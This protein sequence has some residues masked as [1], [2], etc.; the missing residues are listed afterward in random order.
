M[1]NPNNVLLK[2]GATATSAPTPT[3]AGGVN[4][5]ALDPIVS[6]AYSDFLKSTS[7]VKGKVLPSQ[8]NILRQINYLSDFSKPVKK[9]P[10][11]IMK[12]L[13][14]RVTRTVLE[15]LQVLDV[16]RRAVISAGKEIYDLGAGQGASFQDFVSQVK[17]PTFGV[18]RFVNTGNKN[19]DRLLGFAGDVAADPMTYITLGAGKF[20][21]ASGRLALAEEL[22]LKG[23]SEE[24][25]QKAGVRGLTGLTSAERAAYD[26][27]KAGLYFGGHSGVRIPGTEMIGEG[28]GRTLSKTRAGLGSTAV[29]G[30]VRRARSD[31]RFL[32]LTE[33]LLA[34]KGSVS[35]VDA[36]KTYGARVLKDGV[37]GRTLAELAQDYGA[38]QDLISKAP[39]PA[40]VTA[41]LERGVDS[42][43]TNAVRNLFNKWHKKMS[44]AG[45]KVGFLPDY[46]PRVW[47]NEGR[48][49]FAG[50]DKFAQDARKIFGVQVNDVRAPSAVRERVFKITPG[51]VYDIGGKKLTFAEDSIDEINRVFQ[52]EFGVKVLEDDINNLVKGYANNVA[53]AIGNQTFAERLKSVGVAAAESDV[54]GEVV[55]VAATKSRDK[56][57]QKANKKFIADTAKARDAARTAAE[58]MRK[59]YTDAVVAVR[60]NVA[61]VLK[62]RKVKLQGDLKGIVDEISKFVSANAAQQVDLGTQG[63]VLDELIARTERSIEVA[64]AAEREAANRASMQVAG[65]AAAKKFDPIT[66][67]AVR[68]REVAF[69]VLADL[70]EA[71]SRL[72]DVTRKIDE[73]TVKLPTKSQ[74]PEE[75]R[76]ALEV[77]NTIVE[78]D[79]KGNVKVFKAPEAVV[80]D[81]NVE[82][83][84]MVDG[85]HEEYRNRNAFEQFRVSYHDGN[86]VAA[87]YTPEAGGL[88]SEAR[89][90]YDQATHLRRQRD[91]FVAQVDNIPNITRAYNVAKKGYDFMYNKIAGTLDTKINSAVEGAVGRM[92]AIRF[93]TA[94]SVQERLASALKGVEPAVAEF[95]YFGVSAKSLSPSITETFASLIDDLS[96]GDITRISTAFGS[97][98]NAMKT[99]VFGER[100]AAEFEKL[101]ASRNALQYESLLSLGAAELK[102]HVSN[103]GIELIRRFESE[104]IPNYN[105]IDSVRNRLLSVPGENEINAMTQKADGLMRQA[106]ARAISEFNMIV[107]SPHIGETMRNAMIAEYQDFFDKYMNSV[108]MMNKINTKIT[109]TD[110]VARNWAKESV[111][112]KEA[113]DDAMTRV[114]MHVDFV[115]RYKNVAT[116]LDSKG[117]SYSSDGLGAL[118]AKEVFDT[119]IGNLRS[120]VSNLVV[121]QQNAIRDGVDALRRE[122]R[123]GA[124]STLDNIAE[125]VATD[126]SNKTTIVQS[127][128]Q[129]WLKVKNELN[130]AMRT[131]TLSLTKSQKVEQDALKAAIDAAKTPAEQAKASKALYDFNQKL[132][133]SINVAGVS[134]AEATAMGLDYAN[135]QALGLNVASPDNARALQRDLK[136]LEDTITLAIFGEQSVRPEGYSFKNFIDSATT[137][138]GNERVLEP[139]KLDE[140]IKT[141]GLPEISKGELNT[142]T[143]FFDKDPKTGEYLIRRSGVKERRTATVANAIAD[144]IDVLNSKING[145]SS[146]AE[147]LGREPR[148]P[149]ITEE[150]L[151]KYPD[152][153]EFTRIGNDP[154]AISEKISELNTRRSQLNPGPR[155]KAVGEIESVDNQINSLQ[156]RLNTLSGRARWKPTLADRR[157]MFE[158]NKTIEFIENGLASGKIK[159]NA[160]T[161]FLGGDRISKLRD[162][163]ASAKEELT[164]IEQRSWHFTGGTEARNVFEE[165]KNLR[166]YREGLVAESR[167]IDGELAYYNAKMGAAGTEIAK[168]PGYAVGNWR[169]VLFD[170]RLGRGAPSAQ[171]RFIRDRLEL[172]AEEAKI[173]QF[174]KLPNQS[175]LEGRMQ[176]LSDAIVKAGGADV[177]NSRVNELS[178]RLGSLDAAIAAADPANKKIIAEGMTLDGL[179]AERTRVRTQLT[180]AK[181]LQK[182]IT[183]RIDIESKLQL[184]VMPD[185]IERARLANQ[186][187]QPIESARYQ[188]EAQL[189]AAIGEASTAEATGR[190]AV[191]FYQGERERVNA[192]LDNTKRIGED[193]AM[194]LNESKVAVEAQVKELA[195]EL[196]FTNQMPRLGNVSPYRMEQRVDEINTWMDEAYA[197][198][199]PAGYDERV[200]KTI[201]TNRY[202]PPSTADEIA[203]LGL[204]PPTPESEATLALIGKAKELEAQMLQQSAEAGR[205]DR[206][207]K[208][209]K[210]LPS[211]GAVMKKQIQD[212]WAALPNTGIA[213]PNEINDALTRIMHLDDPKRWSEFWKAWDAYGDLFKAYA[214]LTPRFHIRNALSSTLMNYADGVSTRDMTD[215]VKYWRMFKEDPNGWLKKVPAAQRQEVADAVLGV[216]GSGGGRYSEFTIGGKFGTRNRVVAASKDI[217]TSVEGSVRLGMA[218]NTIRGGGSINEAA[219]RITRIHFNYSQLSTADQ[220]V[221]KIIPFWTFMSRNI[222]LQMQQMWLKPRVYQMYASAV[223]N[224]AGE[225]TGEITPSW[226][227]ET[228]MFKSPVGSGYIKPDLAWTALPNQFQQATTASGLLAQTNPA[229]RVPL[230]VLA[231]KKFFTGAPLKEGEQLS[232]AADALIPYL[233]TVRSLT[234]MKGGAQSYMSDAANAAANQSQAQQQLN[235][236]MSFIGLPYAGAPTVSQQRGEV[237]RRQALMEQLRGMVKK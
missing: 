147:L 156:N 85:S 190:Q 165:I 235:A 136:S 157:R 27:P 221:R 80:P 211:F 167:R 159:G 223:R 180:K 39:D 19:L 123:R 169:D 110:N 200:A 6:Q 76:R 189:Q 9:E 129:D 13:G 139:G 84:R 208:G 82:P 218:L 193:G 95:P 233:N 5:G 10:G 171:R 230:E 151:S 63:R 142:I 191:D 124:S 30:V 66:I 181:N 14:N 154:V 113:L 175:V 116:I 96:S 207:V 204:Q 79:E 140:W 56:A 144:Q 225:S 237:L 214:T 112:A 68:E 121:A 132:K 131:S 1:A 115:S 41:G 185:A 170:Q 34:G 58:Q 54:A 117:L 162:A 215:G 93:G 31:E 107:S 203:A 216:F 21:G 182:K 172:L 92:R 125:S 148:L 60:D 26:L 88:V 138:T 168:R 15:P 3:L 40:G 17:D 145:L 104:I 86:Q 105:S 231:G 90:L 59:P 173:Q 37:E 236:I 38:I 195:D 7:S 45:V 65:E 43:S 153:F 111:A 201:S 67:A 163:I 42:E 212:G 209:T 217:G 12:I 91:I 32:Q 109:F 210:N 141:N 35:A 29:G 177:I 51:E 98:S 50:E 224:F 18:G 128:V 81:Q 228:G 73:S 158:L 108:N 118:V 62:A 52:R 102:N 183:E 229:V 22:A 234:G 122:A 99:R 143:K 192:E 176:T 186:A 194:A 137:V 74:M 220:Y 184:G 222:P 61:N 23:A 179:K 219:A 196:A 120:K 64:T 119:E 94:G 101:I 135:V 127:L 106:K 28:V 33:K 87:R 25:V 4:A 227:Q 2:Y 130:T 49:L 134:E 44:D 69:S 188:G 48:A 47:T 205:L 232:Y 114:R 150:M 11:L 83:Y 174:M 72:E 103:Q 57:F 206:M 46:A 24:L 164:M 53:R 70:K 133:K 161:R 77:R 178:S 75:A 202:G 20:A 213:V 146:S 55:D 187:L 71:K 149:K 160:E 155:S 89:G 100:G 8:G 198:I 97:M 197:L 36:A 226:Y 126:L 16:P 199:D 166:S 78:V 152:L